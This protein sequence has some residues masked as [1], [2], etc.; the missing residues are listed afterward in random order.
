MARFDFRLQK[1]LSVKEQ[2]ENQKEIEYAQA[3][4]VVAE[5]KQRLAEFM[6]A[7]QKN[8]E[9][10]R[11]AVSSTI[12]TIEVIRLNNTIERLKQMIALQK[13]RLRAAEVMAEEK[14]LELVEAMKERKALEI[15]KENA[16]E[17]FKRVQDIKERK[18]TDEL[19]SYKY[20]EKLK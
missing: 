9:D 6:G 5:E 19:T 3:L 8:V 20:S 14:R 10:L 13:E 17:E 1:L 2:L 11:T 4:R 7:R 18:I 12:E 16:Y 15:V